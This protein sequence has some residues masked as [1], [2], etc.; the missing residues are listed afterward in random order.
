MIFYGL[1]DNNGTEHCL[2]VEVCQKFLLKYGLKMSKIEKI[3]GITEENK[4]YAH[5]YTMLK[6]IAEG[7]MQECG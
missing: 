3:E 5:M 1:V 2:P 7:T 6:R 4:L